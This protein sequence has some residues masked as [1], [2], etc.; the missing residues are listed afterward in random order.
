MIELS[1]NYSWI[2]GKRLT[3]YHWTILEFSLSCRRFIIELSLDCHW[4]MT[5]LLL[6]SEGIIIGPPSNYHWILFDLWSISYWF[7]FELSSYHFEIP[8]EHLM[9]FDE[10]EKQLVDMGFKSVM[11]FEGGVW[12]ERGIGWVISRRDEYFTQRRI[13]HAKALRRRV[14]S[15]S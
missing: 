13:F 12:G 14:L 10:T 5:G 4:L 6:N 3:P 9:R 15:K 11:F 7:R 8:F 2:I 1:L